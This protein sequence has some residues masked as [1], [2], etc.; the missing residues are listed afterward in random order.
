M[1]LISL[2]QLALV[3]LALWLRLAEPRSFGHG[4]WAAVRVGVEGAEHEAGEPLRRVG[5]SRASLLRLR[6]GGA[7]QKDEKAK[8]TGTCIGIDLGTTYR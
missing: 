2:L 6:G 1:W 7:E 8:V 4:R 5:T 3:L